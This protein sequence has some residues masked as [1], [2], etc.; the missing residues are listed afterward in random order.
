MKKYIFLLLFLFVP[1]LVFAGESCSTLYNEYGN[2]I[3]GYDDNNSNDLSESESLDA[4]RDWFDY[5]I[6]DEELMGVLEYSRTG[7]YLPTSN[8]TEDEA[9]GTLS[10]SSKRVEPG[11]TIR[12]TI[13]GQDDNGLN[14]LWAYYHDE[15]H[16]EEVSGTSASKTFIF[17][18][19]EEGAY[20]Y[21]GYVSGKTS[22]NGRDAVW[23]SPKTITV[24]VVE[25]EKIEID[26]SG[27]DLEI[28][29]VSTNPNNPSSADELGFSV[30]VKNIGNETINKVSGGIWTKMYTAKMGKRYCDAITIS[31]AP[32]AS[33]TVDCPTVQRFS[34]KNEFEFNIDYGA[35]VQESNENNNAF[36]KLVTIIDDVETSGPDLKILSIA[37]DPKNP[38]NED[39]LGFNLTVK[40][41]GDETV[42]R[43]SG[44]IWTRIYSRS[45]TSRYCDAITQSIAPGEIV[46]VDCP[47]GHKFSGE[48]TFNFYVDANHKVTEGS[49]DNN[50]F[51]GKVVNVVD[52]VEIVDAST[53]ATLTVSDNSPKTGETFY[54]TVTGKDDDGVKSVALY[55]NGKWNTVNCYGRTTCSERFSISKSA[56][57]T[58]RYY[59][60]VFA[61]DANKRS[62]GMRTNPYAS[63]IS[64][65]NL[66]GCTETDGGL[67]Y[68][69]KGSIQAGSYGRVD[70]CKSVYTT[71]LGDV[72][73]SIGDG[74]GASVTS[75]PYLY[76]A[77]CDGGPSFLR[78]IQCDCENGACK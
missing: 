54:F 68:Y 16:K 64:V 71:Q 8:V 36:T 39:E 51:N 43:V 38:T 20:F 31:L 30:V 12:L 7:C 25:D 18:E 4:V 10:V 1:F 23:T 40:N 17:T 32:G 42:E 46:V 5:D 14:Y 3:E 77:Y 61:Y 15:W 24:V 72:V 75:G 37:T 11:D 9:S 58:Y 41:V 63:S 48:N 52:A 47:T 57:G 6:S 73:K 13:T 35:K 50:A 27:P 33:A 2:L 19:E 76:E 29:S 74:G 56:S 66:S 28:Q 78:V 45:M 62:I 69:T 21:M 59:G 22:G 70:V 49:E 26:V 34:G 65:S 67:N 44:G 55:I 53:I 60:Y